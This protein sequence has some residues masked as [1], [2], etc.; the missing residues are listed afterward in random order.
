LIK[1]LQILALDLTKLCFIKRE[2]A[3]CLLVLE[4]TSLQYSG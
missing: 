2:D 4:H 3:D 1:N